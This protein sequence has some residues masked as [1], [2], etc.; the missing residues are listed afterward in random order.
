MQDVST[1]G[2]FHFEPPFTS[3]DHLVGAA[4]Q[5][6][7][8]GEAERPGRLE[9]DPKSDLSL[10]LDRQVARFGPLEDFPRIY[11]D[12]PIRFGKTGVVAHQTARRDDFTPSVDC[13]NAMACHQRHDPIP[14]G[15]EEDI[16]ANDERTGMSL[17]EGCEGP[18]EFTLRAGIHDNNFSP[19]GARCYLHLSFLGVDS[20][21]GRVHEKSDHSSVR[22]HLAQQFQAFWHQLGSKYA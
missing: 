16:W 5:R 11:A 2:K 12:L 22:H 18:V 7:R 19:E 8:K 20:G 9:I 10:L 4:E 13:R 3:F 6:D 14:S 21:T 1:V 17:D 15:V